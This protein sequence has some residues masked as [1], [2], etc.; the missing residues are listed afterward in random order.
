[1]NK[2]STITAKRQ[3]TIPAKLFRKL[4]FK[5]GQKVIFHEEKGKLVVESATDILD[6][7]QGSVKIPERFKGMEVDEIIQKATTEYFD[8]PM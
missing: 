8:R 6:R 1:M 5:I 2:V 4:G 3:L 7:L